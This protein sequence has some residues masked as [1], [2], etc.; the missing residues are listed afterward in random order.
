MAREIFVNLPI[1]DLQK[2]MEFFRTLGFEF[3]QQFTDDKAAC[4]I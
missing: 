1:R 2:S 4:M 3:N